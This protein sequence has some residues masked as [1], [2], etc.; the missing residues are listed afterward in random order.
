MIK[1]HVDDAYKVLRKD[2]VMKNII[3][4]TGKLTTHRSNDV[5]FSML[6]SITSQQLSTKAADTIFNRFLNLFPDGDPQPEIVRKMNLDMLRSVGLS[7]SKGQYLKN[8]ADF[9]VTHGLEY[10]KLN[11]M[12]DDDLIG[13]LTQIK[14]VGRWTA[15]MI[16]MFT[17]NRP[18]VLPVDDLGIRH[19]MIHH[20]KL[21]GDGKKLIERI[22]EVAEVWRPYRTLACR[23]L[24]RYRDKSS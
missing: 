3:K 18:D 12:N 19:A 9:S 16:L 22:H 14:G 23:H 10:R 8:I 24:W 2:P 1:W 15:E 5:Y 11:K 21:K 7:Y 13:Y 4:S 6:R 17:M 20:Y